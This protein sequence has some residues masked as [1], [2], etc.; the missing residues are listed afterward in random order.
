MSNNWCSVQKIK[1]EKGLVAKGYVLRLTKIYIDIFLRKF[2]I[3][4]EHILCHVSE[5]FIIPFLIKPNKNNIF[6]KNCAGNLVQYFV[7]L[8]YKLSFVEKCI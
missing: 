2:F 7:V 4:R 1:M 3:Y 6:F 8:I 5:H